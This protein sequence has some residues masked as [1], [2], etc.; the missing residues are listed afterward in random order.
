VNK[1]AISVVLILFLSCSKEI[2]LDSLKLYNGIY[3]LKKDRNNSFIF[4]T[5]LENYSHMM[6]LAIINETG[7]IRYIH[8]I[9]R[10]GNVDVNGSYV[11][12]MSSESYNSTVYEGSNND[13]V[14]E[15]INGKYEISLKTLPIKQFTLGTVIQTE[16]MYDSIFIKSN[17]NFTSTKKYRFNYL[18]LD[19]NFNK[20]EMGIVFLGEY[21]PQN[22]TYFSDKIFFSVND[23]VLNYSDLHSNIN[24][25]Y[26]FN[27]DII[28]LKVI[29][30]TL[31]V[32]LKNSIYLI[33]AEGDITK[34][35]NLLLDME[36]Y[37]AQ[38]IMECNDNS[39]AVSFINIKE[40]KSII[41]EFNIFGNQLN[42]YLLDRTIIGDFYLIKSNQPRVLYSTGKELLI[43]DL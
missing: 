13:L 11:H 12:I 21:F 37:S 32:L 1:Y 7:N 3:D 2:S 24:S 27:S 15:V 10:V 35:Y 18:L 14:F 29:N 5:N 19:K 16:G 41:K 30:K 23:R 43:K 4:L 42:E 26:T 9:N 28:N 22:I 40:N 25:V 38:S 33:S 8:Q 36:D 34:G 6:A 39:I 31:F 17:K 20:I